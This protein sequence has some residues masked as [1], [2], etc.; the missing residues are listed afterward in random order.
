MS[1]KMELAE[2][3]A[4]READRVLGEL[5]IATLPVDPLAIAEAR[6]IDVTAASLDCSGCLV[7]A[8]DNFGI[9][10]SNVLRNEG[11]ERFTVAHELGHFHLPGHPQKIFRNGSSMHRSRSGFISRDPIEREAD[12]FAASLLMPERL[13]VSALRAE[14]MPG[15]RGIR[16]LSALCKVSLT[17]T[18]LRYARFSDDPVAVIMSEGSTVLWCEM[19]RPLRD[20]RNLT[21]LQKGAALPRGTAS[22]NFNAVPANIAQCREAEGTSDLSL[23]LDGAPVVEMMEDVF[24][25]GSY[26]KTLTVLFTTDS[27]DD[28][29]DEDDDA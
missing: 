25:L 9:L 10:Y 27:I 17:A 19:S 7:K 13:F 18:A 28:E 24:G 8:G 15:I 23:W 21:W 1:R 20:L 4:A 2:R 26:G 16:N 22:S 3:E 29:D 12:L 6:G 14:S 5:E 11:F